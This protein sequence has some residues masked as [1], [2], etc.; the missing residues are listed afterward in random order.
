MKARTWP[1]AKKLEIA[2]HSLP[3]SFCNFKNT[4]AYHLGRLEPLSPSSKEFYCDAMILPL[5][6]YGD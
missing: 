4:T 6:K 5:T 2:L 1:V 3:P